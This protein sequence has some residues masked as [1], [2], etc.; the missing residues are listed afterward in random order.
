MEPET[1]LTPPQPPVIL[2]ATDFSDTSAVAADWAAEL[3]RQQEARIELVHAVTVP[4]SMPGFVPVGPQL[5]EQVQKAALDRLRETAAALTGRGITVDVWLGVGTPS[6]VILERA[7]AVAPELIALGTRGLSGLKHILLGSTAQRVVQGA[8][9][10]VLSVHPQDLGRHRVIRSIL[11]PTDFS[12]DAERAIHAALRILAPLE[13]SEA[14]EGTARLTLIHAFN[15]PIE[16]TAYGPI[17]TSIHFLRDTGLEAERRL[18]EAVDGL[19]REGLT[20]DWVARE[21]DPVAVIAQEA[22][23]RGVDLIAMGTHGRS[24]LAHL[25]LGSTAERVVQHSPC[26]VLTVRR[27]K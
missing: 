10:P 4:T 12:D 21:G 15:L 6:Q 23:A 13:T 19:A 16:Y 11:V 24:G 14:S 20:V 18:Q 3:A 26:P 25:F 2:V 17:P 27:P 7:D 5:S 22:E 9:C 1:P 8:R